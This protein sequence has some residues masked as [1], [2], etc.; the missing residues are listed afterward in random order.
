MARGEACGTYR[1]RIK[2][3]EHVTFQDQCPLTELLAL[4]ETDKDCDSETSTAV[5]NLCQ[6]FL[7]F[8]DA[9]IVCV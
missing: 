9:M 2:E 7:V 3:V 8:F 6:L 1:K 5:T 4:G